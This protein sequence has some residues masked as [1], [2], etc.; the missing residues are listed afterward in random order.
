[1][2]MATTREERKDCTFGA[3][4]DLCAPSSVTGNENSPCGSRHHVVGGQ[5]RTRP[6]R[7]WDDERVC[8]GQHL[9]WKRRS[10]L[11]RPVEQQPQRDRAARRDGG[12]NPEGYL[13][14]VERPSP[15]RSAAAPRHGESNKERPPAPRDLQS[16]RGR[17][18]DA[19]GHRRAKMH[20]RPG[21]PTV[22]VVVAVT[23]H[24]HLAAAVSHMPFTRPL[25][26][27][28]PPVL[29]DAEVERGQ[30][31]QRRRKPGEATPA[32]EVAQYLLHFG[33]IAVL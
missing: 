27:A 6:R 7:V 23:D 19:A 12:G 10:R 20:S 11:H 26:P 30:V 9:P 17:S 31:E 24:R 13:A 25:P 21:M 1:M 5:L 28:R 33:W 8:N 4:L 32:G 18:H 2:A 14:Q 22:L 29:V 3:G 16:D 15:G